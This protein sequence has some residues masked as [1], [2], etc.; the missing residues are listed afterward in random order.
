MDDHMFSFFFKVG[1]RERGSSSRV[2]LVSVEYLLF[3][4]YLHGK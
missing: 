4:V 1:P 3:L 2:S